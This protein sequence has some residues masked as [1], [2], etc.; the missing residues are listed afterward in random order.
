MNQYNFLQ[1]YFPYATILCC[2]FHFAQAMQKNL[3]K[4]RTEKEPWGG[5]AKVYSDKDET[6]FMFCFKCIKAIAFCPP[7]DMESFFQAFTQCDIW[8]SRLD[9]FCNN[10]FRPIWLGF[11]SVQGVPPAPPTP[12]K[13]PKFAHELWNVHQCTLDDVSRTNN[14]L[15]GWH[16]GAQTYFQEAGRSPFKHIEAL[17]LLKEAQRQQ[18]FG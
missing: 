10:Y 4:N 17:K 15:E 5:L 14:Y 7:E 9:E 8:D 13:P 3:A 6:M 18:L 2:N 12:A 1:E 11:P 16:N